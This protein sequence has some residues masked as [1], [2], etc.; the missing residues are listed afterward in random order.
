MSYAQDYGKLKK[1]HADL[2][3]VNGACSKVKDDLSNNNW[4]ALSSVQRNTWAEFTN[5]VAK[6]EEM[7]VLIQS[8]NCNVG[9][10]LLVHACSDLE[11]ELSWTVKTRKG[12]KSRAPL[13]FEEGQN[14]LHTV[15]ELVKLLGDR[16]DYNSNSQR[17]YM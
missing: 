12:L 6:A 2:L 5:T 7:E 14:F 17:L 1:V 15:A 8:F 4:D 10:R 13:T 11:A 3:K 16:N 9:T